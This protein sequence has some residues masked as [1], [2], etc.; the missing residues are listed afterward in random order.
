[1]NVKRAGLLVVIMTMVYAF[2]IAG[3]MTDKQRGYVPA[4]AQ[5][6]NGEYLAADQAD[7]APAPGNTEQDT[8]QSM[9]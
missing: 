1:M 7:M 3:C 5:E 2:M 6:T 8:T 4:A 9:N